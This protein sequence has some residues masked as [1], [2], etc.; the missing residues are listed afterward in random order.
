MSAERARKAVLDRT[1]DG[2]DRLGPEAVFSTVPEEP[3]LVGSP[4]QRHGPPVR[5]THAFGK[6]QMVAE[7]IFGDMACGA[8][9]FAV[10]AEPLVK[11]EPSAELYCLRIICVSVR[12]VS[13]KRRKS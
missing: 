13:W 5:Y 9:Y 2:P 10:C 12:G 3:R 8:R 4:D 11:K 1:F 7:G 6:G